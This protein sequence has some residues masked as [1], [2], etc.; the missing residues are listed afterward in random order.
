LD[1][2][3]ITGFVLI[4]ILMIV[5]SYWMAPS[6]EELARQQEQQ[7]IEDSL[8][9]VAE[10][11]AEEKPASTPS[12]TQ[13]P[14]PQTSQQDEAPTQLGP[15]KE[16]RREMGKFAQTGVQDTME[17]IVET[18]LYTIVF[19]NLGGGPSQ[20][21]LKEYETWDHQPVHLLADTVGSA[22]SLGFLSTD[23][24]NVETSQILFEKVTPGSSL[25]I[26]EGESKTLSYALPVQNE[27]RILFTYTFFGD[28][29]EYDLD[30]TFEGV[31]S[32]IVGGNV[33]LSWTP[34]LRFTEKDRTQETTVASAYVY[35]GGEMEQLKLD[36]A[37]RNENTIN[38]NVQ[39]VASRTKFFTQ[40]IKSRSS[41]R[42][43]RL[44]G[45]VS[46]EPSS[47]SSIHH[48]TTTMSSDFGREGDLQ[49]RMFV[50]PLRYYD[51][52][53][54]DKT[55]YEMVDAGW[56]PWFSDV[57]VQFAIIPFLTWAGGLIGNYG[58]AIII[59]AILVKLILYPLTKKSFESMAAMRELQPE[60]KAIQEK[61]KENPQKLQKETMKL[62]KKTGINPMGACLPNLLQF[63]VLI[64][65]WRFFQNSIEIR[66]KTF[67]WATDLS[68]PDYILSL[69]FD[70]PFLGDQVA[71][72]VLLMTATMVV[73][74]QLTGSATGTPSA[75]G[76][77]M[78]AFQYI[79]P[80]VLLFVFNN[81]AAGL[82][83]YYLIYNALSIGQQL[84]INKQFDHEGLMEGIDKKRAKKLK[85]GK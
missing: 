33:D 60:M 41:S 83:L 65:L 46:G 11:Q 74:T 37:G 17:T 49:Y 68:A 10:A 82:S 50:G 57:L 71:G 31:Q 9:A 73:Q 51:L 24:F 75:G 77:N 21:I 48:Y 32:Q 53:E 61:Y 47:A 44:V 36:E 66:Q 80:L 13:A 64:T 70:I 3:T 59:F 12:Q 72:F 78:K 58:I 52:R 67:L 20:F 26:Q 42:G 2:K 55:A 14:K 30:I 35:A 15:A 27:G 29:Y 6:Q 4:A 18:P 69:P 79:L 1:R 63:P 5:W 45:Q 25:T 22:Y 23:N 62:Y 19:S 40:I 8:K 76:P 16:R 81:F 43:A 7:R 84:L 85:K 38:G 34:R 54:F 28:T 39:W 56:I